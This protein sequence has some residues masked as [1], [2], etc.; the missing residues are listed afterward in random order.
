MAFT[1]QR[2]A[3]GMRSEDGSPREYDEVGWMRALRDRIKARAGNLGPVPEERS[4][5]PESHQLPR[6]KDPSSEF[7]LATPAG[8]AHERDVFHEDFRG[9]FIVHS[10]VPSTREG[11]KYDIFIYLKRRFDDRLT[12]NKEPKLNVTEAQFF[13]GS[14]WGNQIFKGQLAGEV[15]GVHTTAYRPFL[16][17]CR[18]TFEDGYQTSLYRRIDF[19]M[20]YALADRARGKKRAELDAGCSTRTLVIAVELRAASRGAQRS[21]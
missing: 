18:V 13:F 4:Q 5:P 14:K 17:T 6:D 11:Y 19:E 21:P 2:G 15:I 7:D 12:R 16:C 8:R 1:E 9:V 10:L 3:V 20:G